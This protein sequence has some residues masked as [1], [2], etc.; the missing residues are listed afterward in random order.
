VVG[1]ERKN[2]LRSNKLKK[3]FSVLLALVLVCSFSLVTAVPAIAQDNVAFSNYDEATGDYDVWTTDSP[4]AEVIEEFTTNPDGQWEITG[5]KLSAYGR[6]IFGGA[7]T[8]L[9]TI[10]IYDNAAGTS[11]VEY[12]DTAFESIEYPGGFSLDVSDAG[13]TLDADTIYWFGL[14]T[15]DGSI[16]W[17]RTLVFE[18]PLGEYSAAGGSHVFELTGTP[19]EV[20]GSVDVETYVGAFPTLELAVPTDVVAL[21]P[22]EVSST[23]ANIGGIDYS[24]VRFNITLSGPEAFSE[25]RA[26][27]FTITSTTDPLGLQGFNETFELIDGDWVGYWGSE[28]GFPMPAEYGPILV[29]FTVEMS[30]TTPAGAY[31]VAAELVDLSLE[32]VADPLASTVESFNLGSL[33][34]I[35][36]DPTSL[37]FG[38]VLPGRSSEAKTVNITNE[39]NTG[40]KVDAETASAFYIEALTIDGTAVNDWL[41]PPIAQDGVYPASLV[42]T[43]PDPYAA[44]PQT[45][46]IIFWAEAQ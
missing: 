8:A 20:E 1:E 17:E 18:G 43:V 29:D 6:G 13:V 36:L 12:W 23:A 22:F 30:D 28:T 26:D 9:I 32:P 35:S 34:Q 16:G 39:G 38:R 25:P 41:S 14:K 2:K 19:V 27:T 15:R 10:S 3:L 33:T 40:I 42:V 44:G 7:G 46:T 21:D 45:G 11:V 31:T 5:I 24:N 37:D 4:S